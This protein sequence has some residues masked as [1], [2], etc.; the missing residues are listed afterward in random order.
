[1]PSPIRYYLG[2][3]PGK[4]GGLVCISRSGRIVTYEAM[5][6]TEADIWKWF[7]LL[8]TTGNIRGAFIEK[9]HSMPQQGVASSFTFGMGYGGLRMALVAAAIPFQEVNPQTWMKGLAIPPKKKTES[10][11]RSKNRLRGF[12][13]QLFPGLG[14][15]EWTKGE[16][17]KVCDALLI[18]EFCRRTWDG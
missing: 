10:K 9:V 5:P 13:Q 3:D 12:A 4:T 1:M 15:W 11:A 6:L 7:A 8:R 2:I 18:A 17:L 16:Q 14:A